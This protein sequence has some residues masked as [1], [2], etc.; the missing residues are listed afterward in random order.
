MPTTSRSVIGRPSISASRIASTT[1][2]RGVSA[3]RASANTPIHRSMAPRASRPSAVVGTDATVARRLTSASSSAGA[4]RNCSKKTSP[5]SGRE[6]SSMK[7]QVPDSMNSSM[8]PLTSAPGGVFVLEDR[9]RGEEGVDQPLVL[10]VQ[11]RIDHLGDRRDRRR[12]ARDRD[13][14]L[15]AERLPVLRHPHDVLVL[16]DD[17]EAAVLLAAG[18]G[19]DAAHGGEGLVELVGQLGRQ[20]VEAVGAPRRGEDVAFGCACLHCSCSSVVS[21]RRSPKQ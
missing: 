10:P 13:A 4:W 8:R 21:P 18:D 20:V 7:S 19:A 11:R 16:G 17:P 5:G 3:R 2:P 14:E 6:K 9:V 12:S 15:G 1:S